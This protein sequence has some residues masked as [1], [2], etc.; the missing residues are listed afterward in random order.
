[1]PGKNDIEVQRPAGHMTVKFEWDVESLGPGWFNIDNLKLCLYGKHT[2]TKPEL[3]K[4]TEVI[5][6]N[7]GRAV[8]P[9][10]QSDSKDGI[11]VALEKSQPLERESDARER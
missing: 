1:M 9:S 3:L 2:V 6:V 10:A 11:S 4:L 5:I 8:V 7:P